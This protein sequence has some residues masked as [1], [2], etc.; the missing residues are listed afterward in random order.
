MHRSVWEV[1]GSR[2]RVGFLWGEDLRLGRVWWQPGADALHGGKIGDFD[3]DGAAGPVG[4]DEGGL[5]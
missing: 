1:G 5:V 4:E 2:G 3:T